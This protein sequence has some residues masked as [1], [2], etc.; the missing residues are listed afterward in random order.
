VPPEKLAKNW[1]GDLV[2][3][4]PGRFLGSNDIG[5]RGQSETHPPEHLGLLD[6]F[7]NHGAS[8]S[9]SIRVD[10]LVS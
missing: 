7:V 6:W 1:N 8:T 10:I 2:L 4:A 9:P 5:E 3:R